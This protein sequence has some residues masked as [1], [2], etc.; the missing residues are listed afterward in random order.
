VIGSVQSTSFYAVAAARFHPKE[1]GYDF[2]IIGL[3]AAAWCFVLLCIV[4]SPGGR[5]TIHKELNVDHVYQKLI[6]T[7]N[8][9]DRVAVS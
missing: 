5:K 3:P 6:R 1:C 2:F 8:Q 9:L 7:L 4:F